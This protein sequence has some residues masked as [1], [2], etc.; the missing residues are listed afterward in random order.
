M[1]GSMKQKNK[2]PLDHVI[3]QISYYRTKIESMVKL[4]VRLSKWILVLILLWSLILNPSRLFQLPLSAFT[5]I[6]NLFP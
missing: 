6:L 2:P 1:S 5:K 3:D 4:A